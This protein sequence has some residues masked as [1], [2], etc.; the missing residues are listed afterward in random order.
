MIFSEAKLQ[1]LSMVFRKRGNIQ[2]TLMAADLQAVCMY[3]GFRQM[4]F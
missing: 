1:F 3:T 4:N 2:S